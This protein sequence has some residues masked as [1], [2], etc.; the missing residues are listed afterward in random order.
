M[1]KDKDKVIEDFSKMI[2][3]SWTWARLTKEE[4]D[5]FMEHISWERTKNILKGTYNQRYEIL[6]ELYF[7]YLLGIGYI[8][9]GWRE[10]EE[11][12]KF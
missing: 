8:P 3:D 7:F 11:E 1:N 4:K 6:N 9:I 5:I 2:K 10:N 12:T